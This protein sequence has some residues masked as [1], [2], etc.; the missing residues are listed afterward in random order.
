MQ[1]CV[2]PRDWPDSVADVLEAADKEFLAHT[3]KC[4]YHKELLRKAEEP[5]KTGGRHV[6]SLGTHGRPPLASK[7]RKELDQQDHNYDRWVEQGAPVSSLSLRYRG[8]EVA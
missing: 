2:A 1:K 7:E 6:R 4:P 8:E 5:F 3:A